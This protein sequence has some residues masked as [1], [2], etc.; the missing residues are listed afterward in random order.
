MQPAHEDE[1]QDMLTTA[2]QSDHP[3]FI[4]YP[5]GSG[6]GISLKNEPQKIAIGKC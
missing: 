1:L 3:C 5:R 4:R 6:I 2:I